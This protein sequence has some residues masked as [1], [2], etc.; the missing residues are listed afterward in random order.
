MRTAPTF[1]FTTLKTTLSMAAIIISLFL[2][3]TV[4]ATVIDFNE[5]TFVTDAPFYDNP[6]HEDEYLDL[7]VRIQNTWIS[8]T[9]SNIHLLTSPG[10]SFRFEGELPTFFS[11]NVT[12]LS[13]DAIYLGIFGESGLI[14]ALTSSGWRGPDQPDVPPVADELLS[15]HHAAGIKFITVFSFY[16]QRLGASIDNL[17]FTNTPIPV[18]EPSSIAFIAIGLLG[19][20]LRRVR[21]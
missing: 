10:A 14:T 21:T 5:L 3:T 20:L 17:T 15:F 16:G 12:S 2:P 13:G 1:I 4:S 9:S 11:M 7:G 18:P 19:L 8:G 6:L